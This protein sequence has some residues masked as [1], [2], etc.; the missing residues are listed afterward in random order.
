MAR[1]PRRL[2]GRRWSE[3][4]SVVTGS[5]RVGACWAAVV[6]GCVLVCL[7]ARGGWWRLVFRR[8]RLA[9]FL[10]FSVAGGTLRRLAG[11]T[12]RLGGVGSTLRL[13]AV[14]STRRLGAAGGVGCVYLVWLLRVDLRLN[15]TS[16]A[17]STLS[18]FDAGVGSTVSV[19]GVGGLGS[20]TERMVEKG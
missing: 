19:A 15:C 17:K 4:G 1:L 14:G 6:R 5:L 7:V 2:G 18:L 11:S 8:G 13:G 9:G 3:C 16:G 10:G 12:L 20:T